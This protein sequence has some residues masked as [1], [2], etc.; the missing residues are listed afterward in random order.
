MK[1]KKLRPLKPNRNNIESYLPVFKGFY[2]SYWDDI[3]FYGEDEHFG[4]PKDF[5]FWEYLD[6]GAYKEALSKAFC[7]VIEREM[8]DFVER[9][10][11]QSLQSPKYYNFE[12]DSINCIIRPKKK[13][14][15]DFIYSHKDAFQEYLTAHLKSRDG[16][17]SFHSHYFEDWET[18]TNKFTKLDNKGITLGFIL[19]FIAEEV[20]KDY[21]QNIYQSFYEVDVY[22]SEFYTQEFYD[23]V[24]NLG[25]ISEFV[26][27]DAK[28]AVID[29]YEDMSGLK[30][31]VEEVREF[32]HRKYNEPDLLNVVR[33]EFAD[34]EY[35]NFEAIIDNILSETGAHTLS[36]DLK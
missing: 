16:F 12:N 31:Q 6:W 9:I 8:S 7:D 33:K 28:Q 30:S 11:Y 34:Y 22:F 32:V 2:G 13:A 18:D 19:D 10:E 21:E 35:V 26:T 20:D 15:K 17:I 1:T 4:L 25:G 14:I 5:P 29:K 3:D 27:E 23:F 24:D 36:M